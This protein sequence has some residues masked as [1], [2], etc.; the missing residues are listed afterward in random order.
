M[1]WLVR[2]VSKEGDTVLDPFA[3]SFTTGVACKMLGRNFIGIEIDA[4]YCV[5]GKA[6]MDAAKSPQPNLFDE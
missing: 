1:A 3:G 2:L 6:R 5:I 4:D